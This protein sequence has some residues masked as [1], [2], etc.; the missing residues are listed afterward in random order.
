MLGYLEGL[1][2]FG[3]SKKKN[4]LFTLQKL[5]SRSS[6]KYFLTNMEKQSLKLEETEGGEKPHLRGR[7]PEQEQA[8]W[9][10]HLLMASQVKMEDEQTQHTRKY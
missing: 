2:V 9:G 6:Q 1:E 3:K 7:N 8:H 4:N 10:T 5:S